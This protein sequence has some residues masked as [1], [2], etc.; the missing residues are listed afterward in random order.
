MKK[1]KENVAVNVFTK[2]QKKTGRKRGCSAY[3]PPEIHSSGLGTHSAFVRRHFL[4]LHLV[5]QP[6]S[7]ERERNSPAAAHSAHAAGARA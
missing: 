7:R 2:K 3:C 6:I 5:T 4:V 1:Q